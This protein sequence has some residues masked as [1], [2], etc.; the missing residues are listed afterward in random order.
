[1]LKLNFRFSSPW[2]T[3]H[4]MKKFKNWDSINRWPSNNGRKTIFNAKSKILL[5][6]SDV[7]KVHTNFSLNSKCIHKVQDLNISAVYMNIQE[8]LKLFTLKDSLF[9]EILYKL[10]SYMQHVQNITSHCKTPQPVDRIYCLQVVS[11]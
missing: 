6:K 9:E 1:M 11:I 7:P 2:W 4:G 5:I 8:D 3:K 10:H